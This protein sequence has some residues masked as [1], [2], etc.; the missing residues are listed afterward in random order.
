L[1]HET[2]ASLGRHARL[3]HRHIRF[4]ARVSRFD[5]TGCV[6]V[7][8]CRGATGRCGSVRGEAILPR[9]MMMVCTSAWTLTTVRKDS[10]MLSGSL[11][12]SRVP[13]DR[14]PSPPLPS[15][16]RVA[17]LPPAWRYAL[18]C[19]V[20]DIDVPRP[21]PSVSS[22]GLAHL[23]RE[24]CDNDR[25][26]SP[27][28]I[29]SLTYLRHTHATLAT[30]GGRARQSPEASA[31]AH[32]PRSPKAYRTSARGLQ[33]SAAAVVATLSAMRPY[34]I[35]MRIRPAPSTAPSRWPDGRSRQALCSD[36][37]EQEN[38]TTRPNRRPQ[39]DSASHRTRTLESSDD[40]VTARLRRRQHARCALRRRRAASFDAHPEVISDQY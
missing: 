6:D 35:A 11:T 22:P 4:R 21:A 3:L 32:P 29:D 37:C 18:R 34:P 12:W 40:P 7:D 2:D 17:S 13:L 27:A 26:T 25:Y 9:A 33:A 1:G 23:G 19:R 8:T 30:G 38:K 20:P 39:F 10:V 31:R 24:A 5:P 15:Q 14:A 28:G 16:L 36:V